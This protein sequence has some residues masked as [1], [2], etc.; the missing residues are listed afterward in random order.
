[1]VQ[2]KGGRVVPEMRAPV[3]Q[4]LKVN[5][6]LGYQIGLE[7]DEV[8]LQTSQLLAVL[9]GV[10]VALAPAAL[11]PIATSLHNTN[12]K[13]TLLIVFFIGWVLSLLA[14]LSGVFYFF[15]HWQAK[16]FNP[17][18]WYGQL[19]DVPDGH[20]IFENDEILLKHN[21]AN[22]ARDK[23]LRFQSIFFL[24]GTGS[25]IVALFILTLGLI[26]SW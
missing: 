11:S 8:L 9:S 23:V 16:K 26:R 13:T 22:M 21:S 1:M 3:R 25:V 17:H 12:W 15:L 5:R 7:I 24:L 10:F 14:V 4:I 18:Y 20:Q 2:Q 6:A 19:A